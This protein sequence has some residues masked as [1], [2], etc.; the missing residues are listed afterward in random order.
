VGDMKHMCFQNPHMQMYVVN[1]NTRVIL[2]TT[3]KYMWCLWNTLNFKTPTY[4]CMWCFWKPVIFICGG[5][6]KVCVG[7]LVCGWFKTASTQSMY[8]CLY[9]T[10][11]F[12][13][14]VPSNLFAFPILLSPLWNSLTISRFT[15]NCLIN[16]WTKKTTFYY[17]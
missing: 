13:I 15:Q 1:K 4:I 8:V 10:Q 9:F 17:I 14:S 3:Y 5:F 7:V 16:S 2:S 11:F 6:G 12:S